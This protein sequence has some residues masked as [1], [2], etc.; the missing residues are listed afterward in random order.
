MLKAI[1]LVLAGKKNRPRSLAL[2]AVVSRA[3][4]SFL[5]GLMWNWVDS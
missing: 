2:D 4:C 3:V 5:P 1:I